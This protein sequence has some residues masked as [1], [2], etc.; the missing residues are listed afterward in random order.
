MIHVQGFNPIWNLFFSTF[1][2]PNVLWYNSIQIFFE[3]MFLIDMAVQM[4]MEYI[5][6][7]TYEV[8]S[9]QVK[10]LTNYV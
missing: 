4:T 9:D 5:D 1:G 8:V 10:I 2:W 6:E 7:E 3:L